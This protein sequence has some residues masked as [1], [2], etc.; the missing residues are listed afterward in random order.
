MTQ[1]YSDD[2]PS[3]K[4]EQT[5]EEEEL[6]GHERFV[7]WVEEGF[8]EGRRRE[9]GPMLR[10][11]ALLVIILGLAWSASRPKSL[12]SAL[13]KPGHARVVLPIAIVGGEAPPWTEA[14]VLEAVDQVRPSAQACLEGWDGL[15]TNDDGMVVG[16]VVLTPE[17][18]EEAALY[19]QVEAVPE[20][21]AD[22]LGRAL[23]S[24]AW[25]LPETVQSLPFP[26]VGGDR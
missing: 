8:A 5:D 23:G 16:E 6:R 19:D 18:A 10:M 21:V 4:K 9:P 12:K 20:A 11:V 13:V 25:P 7:H 26:I 17:G 15:V 22:C 14:H 2:L 1:R 24:V 3:F